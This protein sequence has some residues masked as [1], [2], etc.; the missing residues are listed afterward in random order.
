MPRRV[1]PALLAVLS[2]VLLTVGSAWLLVDDATLVTWLVKRVE[3]VTGTR[4]S[5]R[6]GAHITRTLSP[7]LNFNSLVV[8]DIEGRFQV[9]TDS[10]LI[11]VNLPYLLV[12]RVDIP[13]LLVGDT[14]VNVN[15]TRPEKESKP[16][17]AI[18]LSALRLKPV[19]HDVRV[20]EISLL[21]E[22]EKLQ[23][24]ASEIRELTLRLEA[25]KDNPQLTAR[26]EVEGE[27]LSINVTLPELHK[28]LKRKQLSF[29]VEV[30][31]AISDSLAV[32]QIDF[33]QSDAVVEANL[34]IFS[35]DLKKLPTLVEGLEIPG[36]L[37][38]SGKLAGTF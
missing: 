7:V 30:K 26:V 25:G 1:I 31:G 16:P 33:S 23:L 37:A 3:S 5:Y 29:S 14:R 17:A 20:S 28:A 36:E 22:G 27:K 6:D 24:P 4:I 10:L 35:P 32:G 19:L 9:E 11:Q 15:R 18:D 8:D 12:G 34:R 21:I 13:R 2:L 38:A